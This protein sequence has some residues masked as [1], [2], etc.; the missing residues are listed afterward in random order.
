MNLRIDIRRNHEE[1]QLPCG[2]VS[3]SDIVLFQHR[4]IV[5]FLL[6]GIKILRTPLLSLLQ[7]GEKLIGLNQMGMYVQSYIV[8]TLATSGGNSRDSCNRTADIQIRSSAAKFQGINGN[9]VE[10]HTGIKLIHTGAQRQSRSANPSLY[11]TESYAWIPLPEQS[12]K[13]AVKPDVYIRQKE[14]LLR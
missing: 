3:S 5:F 6:F 10:I 11:K 7:G 12:G 14:I 13:S 1:F 2:S 9:S 4:I 8:L